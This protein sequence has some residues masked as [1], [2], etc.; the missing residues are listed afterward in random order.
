M[1]REVTSIAGLRDT[2]RYQSG[3]ARRLCLY[4]RLLLSL[5]VLMILDNCLNYNRDVFRVGVSLNFLLELLRNLW[6]LLSHRL[7]LW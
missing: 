6:V 1:P 4:G 3:A 2:V 5:L 7:K